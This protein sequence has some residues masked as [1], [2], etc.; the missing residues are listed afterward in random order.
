MRE[1]VL[2]KLEPM[3]DS[4]RIDI[5]NLSSQKHFFF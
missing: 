3:V 5:I 4:M 2:A 1:I